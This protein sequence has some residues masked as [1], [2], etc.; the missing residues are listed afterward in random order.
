[1]YATLQ[2]ATLAL[3]VY[4]ILTMYH[5]DQPFRVNGASIHSSEAV[6]PSHLLASVHARLNTTFF[7]CTRYVT[8]SPQSYRATSKKPLRNAKKAL[9]DK[10]RNGS[11]S[12]R[13]PHPNLPLLDLSKQCCHI[14]SNMLLQIPLAPIPVLSYPVLSLKYQPSCNKCR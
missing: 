3:L 1:M 8:H 5:P 14:F 12:N 9:L 13:L 11:S 10:E 4:I 7:R 2:A 6:C